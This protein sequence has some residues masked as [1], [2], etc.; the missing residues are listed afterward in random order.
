MDSEILIQVT[1]FYTESN[2]YNGIAVRELATI[3]NADSA[4]L[5]ADFTSLIEQDKICLIFCD[6]HPNP[7]IKAFDEDSPEKQ[8]EKLKK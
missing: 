1:K 7:H 6:V 3:L 4:T 2:D 5:K 8:L